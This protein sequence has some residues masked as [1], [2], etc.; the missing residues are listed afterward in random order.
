MIEDS[1]GKKILLQPKEGLWIP[2]Q[3]IHR[4]ERYYADPDAFIPERF[5]E[6]NKRNIDMNTYLPFGSGPRA[7]IASRF[8]LLQLKAVTYHLLL[9]FKVDRSEKTASVMTLKKGSAQVTA[10]TGFFNQLKLR[11]P[12]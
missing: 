7:C 4:D 9:A 3:A 5:S 6:D 11:N 2:V 12:K 8:A 10:A 1:D